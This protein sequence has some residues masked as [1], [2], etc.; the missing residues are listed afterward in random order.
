MKG[1]IRVFCRVRPVGATG[2]YAESCLTFSGDMELVILDPKERQKNVR[3]KAPQVFKFDRVFGP[4]A[5]QPE[6]Y[7]DTQFLVRSVLD[8]ELHFLLF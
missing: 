7:E 1:N 3:G 8:G 2:D 4:K 6:V 5:M